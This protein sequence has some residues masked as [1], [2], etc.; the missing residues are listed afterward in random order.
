MDPTFTFVAFSHAQ[1]KAST[2]GTF[3]LAE[4][5][6]FNN[7]TDH[8]LNVDP[9]VLKSMAKR[10]ADSEWIRP[11]TEAEKACL[12]IIDDLDSVSAKIKGSATTKKH[13]NNEIWSLIAAKGPPSWYIMISPLD[14]A[15][16]LSLYYMSNDKAFK[17]INLL[18]SSDCQWAII[19]NP[20][21]A[22]WFFEFMCKL[23]IEEVLGCSSTNQH[24]G[25]YGD[26]NAYYGTVKQ[27]G[28]LT[29]HLHMLIWIKGVM[30]PQDM[31]DSILNPDSKFQ[32]K[33]G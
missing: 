24:K 9:E 15:H 26:M 3:L 31:R 21:G 12:R 20:T 10:M 4:R 5:S 8:I 29:L 25:I 33:N 1:I 13:M 19:N 27:Q 7:V 11:M 30:S 18:S 2:T 14:T 32:K 6:K 23:F 17:G 28:R 16:P 22:A